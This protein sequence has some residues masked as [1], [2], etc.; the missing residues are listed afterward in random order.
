MAGRLDG[1][2][3]IVT[4]AGTGIGRAC[5][6]SLVGEGARVLLVGRRVEPLDETAGMLAEGTA[7]VHAA[8]LTDAAAC[9]AVAARALSEWGR[10]DILVNNAGINVPARDLE[11]LSVEDWRRVI[12]ADL[13]APFMLTRAPQ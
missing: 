3:A 1:Q 6:I 9:D 7:V 8:D 11:I 5:A 4:G 10:I 12:D 13:N 2:T